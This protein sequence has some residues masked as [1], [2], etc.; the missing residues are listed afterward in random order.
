[1]GD[2][3]KT[4][5]II[6]VFA[7]L[8]GNLATVIGKQQIQDNWP[9]YRCNPMLMPVASSFA[10][11]GSTVSTSD[12]FSYCV[13]DTMTQFAPN[14][15]QPL[16]YVQSATMDVL[17]QLTASATETTKAQ[18]SFSFNVGTMFGNMFNLFA[19]IML[20]INL[21]MMKMQDT[22]GKL[23]G[24]IVTMMHIMTTVDNTFKSMWAGTPGTLMRSFSKIKK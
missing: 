22:Q 7:V 23:M 9:L 5:A 8:I 12:N 2:L 4:I 24:S 1:M 6:V 14:V 17:S 21:I 16:Q 18:S 11:E 3:E 15:L 20:H 10:P 13:Q 19:G